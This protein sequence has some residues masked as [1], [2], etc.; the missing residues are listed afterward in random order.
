MI[1]ETMDMGSMVRRK[2][3]CM[4]LYWYCLIVE[5]N[6][7]QRFAMLI[8]GTGVGQAAFICF[9]LFVISIDIQYPDF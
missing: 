8:V 7:R 9:P 4:L 2:L 1:T 5:I 3:L 6:G